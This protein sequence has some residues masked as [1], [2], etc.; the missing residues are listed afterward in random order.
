MVGDPVVV[1][2]WASVV[3]P[4]RTK[5]WEEIVAKTSSSSVARVEIESF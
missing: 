1:G 2:V 3:E 4:S 5:S